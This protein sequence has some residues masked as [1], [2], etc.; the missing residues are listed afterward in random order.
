MSR[1]DTYLRHQV[2]AVIG[3]L[4]AHRIDIT[5][6]AKRLICAG[7]PFDVA[8]RVIARNTSAYG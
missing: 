7:A 1:K 6:A 2:D 3:E 8:V 5:A 4:K